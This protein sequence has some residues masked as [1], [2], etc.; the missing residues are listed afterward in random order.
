MVALARGFLDDPRWV[1]HAAQA[2][3]VE[4]AYPPQYGRAHPK[5]WPG[6]ELVHPRLAEAKKA[7]LGG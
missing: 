7:A 2:L 4:I 3:G 5:A 6:A 1:W